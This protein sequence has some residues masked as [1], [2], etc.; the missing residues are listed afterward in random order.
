MRIAGLSAR[1]MVLTIF[2]V[3][4]VAPVLWLVL[5]PTKSDQ[6][7]ISS[8]PFAFGDFHHIALAWKHL[9]AFSSH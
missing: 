7:L 5:A 6:A 1:I 9:D 4:F 3:F 2:A 8:S